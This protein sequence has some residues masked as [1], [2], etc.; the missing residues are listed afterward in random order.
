M[1]RFLKRDM[2]ALALAESAYKLNP[3]SP[4]RLLALA[5]IHKKLG[6]QTESSQYA[7]QARE[8]FEPDDWYNLACLES[9]CGNSD[10]S[11]ENLRRAAQKDSFNPA[12]TRRDPDL[13]WIRDDPRFKEIVGEENA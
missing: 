12:W 7:T 1:L 5:S 8:L 4:H 3:H 6:H 13:E 2:E 11:I 10:A 9:V